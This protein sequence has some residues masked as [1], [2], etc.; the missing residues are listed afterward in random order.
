[1]KHITS[2]LLS[3]LLTLAILLSMIP[4]RMQRGQ[5][6]DR[7]NYLDRKKSSPRKTND[8]PRPKRSTAARP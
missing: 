7:G 3:L 1:M 5:R 8:R 2:K 6:Q 4:R